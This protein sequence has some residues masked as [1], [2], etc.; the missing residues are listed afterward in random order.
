MSKFV[1][2]VSPR[3]SEGLGAS[4]RSSRRSGQR[5]GVVVEGTVGSGLFSGDKSA[6][7]L[8]SRLA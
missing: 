1:R 8:R 3:I 4:F 2:A 5:S 7:A 6:N